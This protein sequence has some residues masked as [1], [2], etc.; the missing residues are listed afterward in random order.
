MNNHLT[1]KRI[2]ATAWT[3]I[4]DWFS[5]NRYFNEDSFIT[6]L[7]YF[8]ITAFSFLFVTSF[9]N[10][11]NNLVSSYIITS[12]VCLALIVVRFL[13][14][15]NKIKEAYALMLYSVN[16]GLIMLTCAEGLRSGVFLFFFPSIISFSFLTDLAN[17][18][19]VLL[20][21]LVGIGSFFMAV[22][23]APDSIIF[24]GVSKE[25]GSGGFFFNVLLSFSLIVW[26]SFN[27]AKENNRKQAELRN[28]EVFLDTIFNSSLHTE[29]IVDIENGLV[30]NCNEH[31][32]SMFSA[33]GVE[34][35]FNIP[36]CEFFLELKGESNEDLLKEMYNVHGNWS[37]ELT[38]C[39]M[40]GTVFPGS[41]SIV[42]F[43]YNDKIYK[44]ITIVD[45]TEKNEILS[46]LQVA[47]NKAEESAHIKSQFLS[48]MSH[49]LRTP[50]NGIIGSS[51]L[52]LQDIF[53]PAQKEQLEILKFSSE[54]M[55]SLINDILD[56]SKLEADRIQLEKAVVD[57]PR[58]INSISSP[59][60]K[61]AEEKGILFKV[62]VDAD[63]KRAVLADPTRL[64]QVLTNLLSNA[65]K[66]TSKG[67]VKL[68]VK[69]ISVKSDS[70]T[71]QFSV[72]DTGIGI[73]EDKRKQIFEQ[74]MQ[75][76]V[77]T[78][79]KYGG[80][81]L[82]LTISQKLVRLMGGDIVVGSK[83]HKGSRFSFEITV[84]VHNSRKKA[85]INESGA[86][87]LNDDQKL[88]GY[89]VLIAEDNPVNM[90]IASKFLDKW[91]VSYEKARNGLEAVSLFGKNNFD[92]VLMDLEMPEM[93]GYGALNAIR[94]INPDIPAI[95]F[96]AAVFDDMK[97][98]LQ[99][100]GFNDYIQKPFKPQD[101]QAK[102]VAFSERQ[103]KTA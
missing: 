81:G 1:F 8:Q 16:L 5:S 66:F 4:S 53:L 83:Y 64:N 11:L 28:K 41:I 79:R 22:T 20:T 57:I 17:K 42:S 60:I 77:K 48:H 89:K 50:L 25:S 44:K 59:F 40:D 97:D 61:Q 76:D 96:T 99:K 32:A 18:K 54:H 3:E 86:E 95:A 92:L 58:L 24:G 39:R 49:E 65:L 72:T 84:P 74:F 85:Y 90:I 30:S 100:S 55:L 12:T 91:G 34:D 102:L 82:G 26:M 36:A 52:L 51:N 101:L 87:I 15:S 37:G 80:T 38:C 21:Y 98:S 43:K 13:L 68:E 7:R 19:N 45:S 23:L 71:I 31:A 70:N 63:L 27:L 62:K 69:G 56:L 67:S 46:E 33:P 35:L 29:I 10:F 6:R 47:K 103:V 9:L 14:D 88:K 73:G 2:A 94:E 78:T 93:D 75:A